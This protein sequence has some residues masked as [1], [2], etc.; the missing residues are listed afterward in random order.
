MN[1]DVRIAHFVHDSIYVDF[2][3]DT[4]EMVAPGAN[5]FY[6]ASRNPKQHKLIHISKAPIQFISRY[7]CFD[8]RFIRSVRKYDIIL[9]HSMKPYKAEIATRSKGGSKLVWIGMGYDYYD[10]IYPSKTDMLKEKTRKIY[11]A[12]EANHAKPKNKV[13]E[14]AKRVLFRA[15]ERKAV[16]SN[17]DYFAPVLE[18]EYHAISRN[19]TGIMPKYISW[20]YD[21]SSKLG[22]IEDE[23]RKTGGSNI[24]LG[25]CA[26]YTNNHIDAFELI[27]RCNFRADAKIIC[28]LN[29]GGNRQYKAAIL[30]MGEQYFD[31]R[32]YP[33]LDFVEFEQYVGLL[34]TCSHAIMN[35]IRQQAGGNILMML[36]LG[37]KVFLDKKNPFYTHFKKMG[38]T[39]FSIEDLE[40]DPEPLI[41]PLTDN[42]KHRNRRIL[43]GYINQDAASKQ[44]QRLIETCTGH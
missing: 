16:L 19:Y 2:A 39:L 26:T 44:T 38:I 1:K 27:K 13:K 10:F 35:H 8:P 24:L 5:D 22:C 23:R 32:F 31:D 21:I 42:A 14:I 33:V 11:R 4:F 9:F 15:Y 25:N 41:N 36:Y 29:Y 43:M 28:P 7:A 12:I 34:A 3:Y 20:N 6:L 17:I 30:E 37:A 40:N 18:E